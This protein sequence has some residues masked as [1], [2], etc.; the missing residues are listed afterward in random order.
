MAVSL[1]RKLGSH[2]MVDFL[3]KNLF[4]INGRAPKRLDF[5]EIKLVPPKVGSI[6][7]NIDV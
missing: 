1:I 3:V 6:K 4:H 5:I 7:V 2:S